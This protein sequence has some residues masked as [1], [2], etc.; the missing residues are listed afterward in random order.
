MEPLDELLNKFWN[1]EELSDLNTSLRS[2]DEEYVENLFVS[3]TKILANNVYQVDMPFRTPFE[4]LKLGD[5]F[6]TAQRRFFA[7]EKRLHNNPKLL[8]D[9][10]K[11]IEEYLALG[12]AKVVPLSLVHNT[13]VGPAQGTE[14]S[15][16]IR[17]SFNKYFV[18]HLC[19][20][21]PDSAS[22]KTRVVFDFSCKTSSLLSFNCI[23]LKGYTVQPDLYDILCR[24]RL[25]KYVLTADIRQMFRQIKTN[26][27]QNVLQNILWRN[28][29]QEPLQCLELQTVSFGQTF[30]PF[31]ACRVLK[32]IAERNTHLSLASIA[33]L[34]QTYIDDVLSAAE[35]LS[36]L[37]TLFSQLNTALNNSGFKLH[38]WQ[39]NSS[40]FLQKISHENSTEKDLNLD[41]SSCKILGLKWNPS[42]DEFRISV[43]SVLDLQPLTKRK[44]LSVISSCFDPLGL[45][46]PII[47]AGKILMQNIWISK[48]DWDT[49]IKDPILLNFWQEFVQNLLQLKDLTIPRYLF[50]SKEISRIDLHGFSDASTLAYGAVVYLRVQ[51]SDNTFSCTLVTA[52]S[53]V[54]PLK[55]VITV[56]RL[57]LCAMLLLSNLVKKVSHIFENKIDFCSVNL[58]TD[59]TI[60]LCWVGSHSSRWTTFVSNRVSQ[61]QVLTEK[62]QWRHISSHNNAAD[63]LSRG[64]FSNKMWNNWFHGPE[65]LRDPNFDLNLFKT[66][67]HI[68]DHPP[69]E[70]K[71]SLKVNTTKEK[72]WM[73][74]LAKFSNFSK[75]QRTVA[76][77]LRFSH[78]LKN[79]ERKVGPLSVSELEAA[80]NFI[81]KII[82]KEHFAQEMQ[83]LLANR[84]LINKSILALK[85]FVDKD[86]FLRVGG[87][88]TYAAIPDSHKH[89]ILLPSHTHIVSLMLKKEHIRLGHAGAQNTL[90]NFRLRFWPLNGL[91]EIKRIIH[92]CITCHRFNATVAEQIM[93]DLP[94]ERVC[95]ARPFQKVG[96]DFAGP[97]LLKSSRL[98]K[99]PL[100]KGY[101]ALFVCMVTKAVHIECVTSLTT[102]AFLATLNRFISRRGNPTII[103][104]DNGTNFLGAKNDLKELYDFFK[105]QSIYDHI[106][107]FLSQNETEWRFIPPRSP[108]WGGIWEAAVKSAKYHLL[109]I[110]GETRVTYEEF[111]TI[112]T[113]IEAILNSR[114]LCALSNDPSDLQSL[115]PGHFLIGTSLT[116]FPEKDLTHLPDNRLSF[117]KICSKI[118]QTFWKR[119]TVDY[120]HRLQQRPKWLRP[121]T[122]LKLNQVV[123]VKDQET[124]PLRWPLA[125][126]IEIIPGKDG[127]VRVA[128]LRTQ[129]GEVTRPISKVCPLPSAEVE[130][131]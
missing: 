24:F 91:R 62:F 96:I 89:P 81:I 113:Q 34:T 103:F 44:I 129:N 102:E 43:P 108:H 119:W 11:F 98:R 50:S 109:R 88:L 106:R 17:H 114:P 5:S 130:T 128:R 72:F 15:P 126:I 78:N 6:V 82:Q 53:R 76:Y 115:T 42:L 107:E 95:V 19:V 25:P 99:A 80:L 122:D 26:P 112:L 70:K 85:P 27:N 39:S 8:E 100:I 58:W 45:V 41:E 22:T 51:Y 92:S 66:T 3:T 21:R 121:L 37:E 67:P 94:K 32:D 64:I 111:S 20:I 90:S 68:V 2:P 18:P 55:K 13:I 63:P 61:I 71:I 97:F 28:S 54:A 49:K 59:S 16:T 117:W 7:L 87:R 79:I 57:E 9:Y 33:L 86:G 29:P 38:K 48:L 46:N 23:S 83:A 69:E 124:P 110:L 116:A 127:R 47:V 65:F 12:H 4:F 36:D 30:A 84:P 35:T 123:L 120:L 73:S 75:T 101:I 125:R 1:Q 118:Q 104:S 31:L 131:F 60:A 105:S 40:E 56:P 52:K 74:F 93:A 14:V 77:V 10:K